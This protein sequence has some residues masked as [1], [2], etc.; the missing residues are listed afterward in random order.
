MP[1]DLLIKGG[2]I[3]DG[4]GAP[5]FTAD[6]AVSRGRITAI[7]RLEGAARRTIDADGLVV[8]PGFIDPHTHYDAQICWDPLVTCS[9][10][11]GVTTVIMGNCGVGLA[12]CKPDEHEV[13]TWNLVHVEAIPYEVLSR[14]LTWDW[15]SFPDYMEAARRRGC[16]INLGFLA[17]LS[18]FRHFVMG[19]EAMS[20]AASEEET[21]AIRELLREAMA[22][23]AFGFSLTVMPQHL[24]YQSQPLA[25]RLA[26]D[27]E[28]RAYAGVLKEAGRGAIEIALTRQPSTVSEREAALLDLL[29]DASGRPVTWLNLRD[30]SDDPTACMETL[31]K[32]EPLL[33]RGARP[34]VAVRP[35]I[36]E[37]HLRN[38]FLF[39]S[40]P[41]VKPIFGQP[42]EA[43][44]KMYADPAFRRAFAA[45]LQRRTVFAN[46]WERAQ[47]K[48][49]V[50][51][52]L[53]S[54][55]WKTVAEAARERG[56]AHAALEVF[57]DLA[58]EDNLDIVYMMPLL[59]MDEERVA[60]K[61]ADPRTMIGISDGG[62]HVDMLCNAGYPTY[63]LGTFVREK[64][65]LTVEHAIKRI[66][67]EPADFF[68]IAGRGRL[69]PGMAADVVIFDPDTV[70]SAIRPEI[71]RDLPGGG[72][73][74]VTQA[75]GIHCT[76]V[77]GQILFEAGQHSG[78]LPGRVLRCAELEPQ[79]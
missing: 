7:G 54:L 35:L 56:R 75:E 45:E 3:V 50:S 42:V 43:Q 60:A 5:R 53:Q 17:A 46:I 67:S 40:M 63:L 36:V 31:R 39:G 11:H 19:D 4:T 12:P 24:G 73:R 64:R 74:L 8:A 32:L 52:A 41:S 47:I 16:G 26:G 20:R 27:D 29:L 79:G 77:N 22:A 72:R 76:I 9:S 13:A 57:F 10:W 66:T 38:P 68:G 33:R 71:R 44:K 34:Q 62:A 55:I 30:R 6:L 58:I 70:A 69:A 28:L 78:A 14:G 15:A 2:A 1:H 51:P 65:A 37:F 49:A 61:F 23:G 21:R 18:P 48:E 59:D 25:C